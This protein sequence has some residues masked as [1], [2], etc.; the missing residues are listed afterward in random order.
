VS[1]AAKITA[2]AGAP[3]RF[4]KWNPRNRKRNS[5][6]QNWGLKPEVKPPKLEAKHA[7]VGSGCRRRGLRCGRCAFILVAASNVALK[8]AAS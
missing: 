4:Q 3:L 6:S 7:E 5:R 8:P 2:G 1:K